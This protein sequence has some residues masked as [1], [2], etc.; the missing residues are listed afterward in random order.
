MAVLLAITAITPTC[1]HTVQRWADL[2]DEDRVRYT[3]C[4]APEGTAAG[5]HAGSP[6]RVPGPRLLANRSAMRLRP[7]FTFAT[8]LSSKTPTRKVIF[9]SG[10]AGWRIDVTLAHSWPSHAGATA[11]GACAATARS[12]LRH[13]NAMS[14][15]PA[16]GD[17]R[18]E[19]YGA[20]STSPRLPMSRSP[21]FN[22]RVTG[23]GVDRPSSI[24]RVCLILESNG[25]ASN[26]S[27]S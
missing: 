18:F 3:T 20:M 14:P 4:A 5:R 19:R 15:P 8:C 6:E 27:Q 9:H 11:I 12:W 22:L 7:D 13:F 25:A 1:W 17:S 26:I 21:T 16:P 2:R 24:R 10:A 23:S